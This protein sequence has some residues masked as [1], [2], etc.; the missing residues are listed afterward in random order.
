[1]K[2][3]RRGGLWIDGVERPGSGELLTV[4]HPYDDSVVGEI[5]TAGPEDVRSAVAS[6]AEAFETTMRR[7]PAYERARILRAT[8]AYLRTDVE[9]LAQALVM[10]VGK[11]IRDARREAGRAADLFELAADL[12][13]TLEGEVLTMDAMRGGENRFGFTLRVPVGVVAAL[14]PFNSPINLS[15]NKIAPA[16]AAGNSVVLKP[17]SKTPFSGLYLANA[18]KEGGLPDGALNVVIG[19]GEQVGTPLVSDPRVRMVTFTGSV[20]A[21]LAITKAAGVKKLALELGSSAANI[22]CI[23]A[24]I[25]MAAKALATSA[26]LSSGQACISAQRLIVHEDVYDQFVEYFTTAARQMTIGD[27]LDDATEIGPM[28][29]NRDI[30]RVLG[31]IGEARQAGAQVLTGGERVGNT[32]AP[33]LVADVPPTAS[34]ACEEAFAPIATIATFRTKEE[35]VRLANDSQFGLQGGVYTNDIVTALFF[36]KEFDVGGLWINDSSR[37]RQ[38]NY[39]FGGMKM[40]GIGRE[41]VRYAMEEMTD[42]RF[43]GV[44]LGPSTG[45]L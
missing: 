3:S 25:P 22:V 44:K 19:A 11:P 10:E 9:Q 18:L 33:T 31:W 4:R 32:I 21:G 29:S 27:P 34:L 41:G 36:A 42:V 15:V 14:A 17:A 13:S 30:E 37:Y 16:L 23:D 35:A 7:M 20:A 40:S 43:V 26:F 6:A 1:M 12:V 28:V 38:D 2:G 39:P 24:D 45:I 5:Q 8:A